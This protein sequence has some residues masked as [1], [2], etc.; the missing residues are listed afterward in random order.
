MNSKVIGDLLI[1]ISTCCIGIPDSRI[2]VWRATFNLAQGRRWWAAVRNWDLYVVTLIGFQ[3][4]LHALHKRII[5]QKN[6]PFEMHPG[7][8]CV[9]S[10]LDKLRIPLLREAALSGKLRQQAIDG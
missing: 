7:R 4:G 6:L 9:G 10:I 8:V 2:S 3:A 1:R 5:T